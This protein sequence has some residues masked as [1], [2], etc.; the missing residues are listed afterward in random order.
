MATT[1]V[2]GKAPVPTL[3]AIS[4]DFSCDC[5]A[6]SFGSASLGDASAN[7][8]QRPYMQHS[9]ANPY[10][11]SRHDASIPEHHHSQFAFCGSNAMSGD[12]LKIMGA[13]RFKAVNDLGDVMPSILNASP[14]QGQVE[15]QEVARRTH[16]RRWASDVTSALIEIE[17]PKADLRTPPRKKT[18]RRRWTTDC[19]ETLQGFDLAPLLPKRAPEPSHPPRLPRRRGS[20]KVAVAPGA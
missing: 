19:P 9:K 20:L 14:L 6:V 17:E 10:S 13:M 7:S 18:H 11:M 3:I 1:S 16:S 5:S 8:L 4:T 12:A 2:Q 15:E